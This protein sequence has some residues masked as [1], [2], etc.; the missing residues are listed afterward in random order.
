VL[1][2]EDLSRMAEPVNWE[3]VRA[4]DSTSMIM[5]PL[6]VEG[7]S[8]GMMALSDSRPRKFT[9]ADQR[10]ARLLGSQASVILAN[11]QLYEQMR[12]G[13]ELQRQLHEQA[14]RDAQAKAILLRE[15]HHRVKN[16][17]AGIVGLLSMH[18]PDLPAS[19]QQWLS[20][21]RERIGTMARAHDLFSG[22]I[23][24]VNLQQLVQQVLP[25]LSVLTPPGVAVKVNTGEVDVTFDTS[26]GVSLAMVLHE[27]CT[28]ALVHGL[29]EE[30]TLTINA[31]RTE[32]G[33]VIEVSDEGGTAQDS[34]STW[35]G[36][37]MG[38]GDNEVSED[39]PWSHQTTAT[40]VRRGTGLF[41]VREL[42]RREL[43][44]AVRLRR[45]T[46]G[47]TIAT[48]EIPLDGADG[49]AAAKS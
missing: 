49:S 31:R 4:Y 28:N 43:K 29:G 26:R 14:G 45:G 35:M 27:L 32:H 25:S 11:N 19:A 20:R 21:V 34:G 12:E 16:N 1:F 5:I 39:V 8:I 41:L 23:E 30:G 3:M 24:R 22:G 18:D 17:L 48:I 40:A 33:A 38:A 15:L 10:L 37:A 42:V 47:G 36:E 44:G 13:L 6:R 2:S 7:Q 46:N 9:D